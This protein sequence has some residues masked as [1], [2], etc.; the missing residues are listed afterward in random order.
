MTDAE[1]LIDGW[2]VYMSVRSISLSGRFLSVD[3]RYDA[4]VERYSILHLIN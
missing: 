4:R 1:L 3:G 2:P